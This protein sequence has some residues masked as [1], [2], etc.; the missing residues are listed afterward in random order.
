MAA[1]SKRVAMAALLSVVASIP[2]A[3]AADEVTELKRAVEQ[4]QEQNRELAHRLRALESA[5]V[6]PGRTS[7]PEPD[8]RQNRPPAVASTPAP[9][10]E[11]P[12]SLEQRVRELEVSKTAQEDAVRS[13][14]RGS[15][16]QS[17]SRINEFVTL[18]GSLEITAGRA[19][20]FNG[21]QRETVALSTAELDLEIKANDWM[22]SV[23]TLAFDS[24]AQ[25]QAATGRVT[26]ANVDRITLDK[27]YVIIGDPRR[28]PIYLKAGLDYLPF[29]TS[30]GVHRSDVLSIATPLTIEA[31][32]L[33]KPGIAI[34]FGLPT[35]PAA[36]P[37][38]P[39]AVPRVESLVLNPLV[40]SAARYLGYQPPPTRAKAP[41]P[42]TFTPEPP[43]LYGIINFYDSSGTDVPTRRFTNNIDARLGYRATGHC[44]RP[45]SELKESFFCPWSIDVSVD[46]VSSLFDSRFL[47][48]EYR[49]F[50]G[51]IGTIPGI[52]ASIKMTLGRFL[53]VGEWNEALRTALFVDG[54]G[55]AVR[56]QPGAWQIALAYQ[57]D[58]NPW[59]E[60]IGAQ[61]NYV[62]IGYSR[63]H[64]LSGV[65]ELVGATP[66]RVGA[67]PESRL[68]VTVGEWVMENARVAVEY[69]HNWDYPL[70][71]GG[72]GRQGDGVFVALTYNW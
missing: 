71:K 34:G 60:T 18:G 6:A 21:Q 41:S 45:Y 63:S 35:P 8:S 61:G 59:V 52:A 27:G 56:M 4:L 64:D 28:F 25:V 10:R 39:V 23:V 48:T 43:P 14:I 19:A 31:F 16:S 42:F 20:E 2:C 72:T 46:Y 33:R 9:R 70:G 55:N 7:R 24:G 15:I 11:S 26:N 3:R 12:G 66:T 44:G 40:S 29:G 38:P 62:A 36:P 50:L 47:Q 30:T 13:I 68:T 5:K 53:F 67:I 51:Q 1:L 32:E 65:V 57:F 37:T 22:T 58:W 54:A 17:G 49:P 69:S